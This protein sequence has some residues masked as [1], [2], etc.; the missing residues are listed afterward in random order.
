[1][2]NAQN[3]SDSPGKRSTQ[4][5]DSLNYHH[6]PKNDSFV[7]VDDRFTPSAPPAPNDRPPSSGIN[8]Y[9]DSSD[10]II[11]SA[12][13]VLPHA[14]EVRPV[15]II[16]EHEQDSTRITD[17]S[18]LHP[19]S[20]ICVKPLSPRSNV[21][22]QDPGKTKGE[23]VSFD[24]D[25]SPSGATDDQHKPGHN[26]NGDLNGRSTL[27]PLKHSC[28]YILLTEYSVLLLILL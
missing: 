8:L 24:H 27:P 22:V 11:I 10:N 3:G 23:Y 1:M 4:S 26:L 6:V 16:D 14:V 28:R 25:R 20:E 7:V 19:Q 2:S 5:T 13:P 9:S 21:V 15:D 18:P 17:S 12:E